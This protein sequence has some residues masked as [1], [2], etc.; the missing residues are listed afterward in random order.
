MLEAVSF[1]SRLPIVENVPVYRPE[2]AV[3]RIKQAFLPAVAASGHRR[4]MSGKE[5]RGRGQAWP[6][7]GEILAAVSTLHKQLLIYPPGPLFFDEIVEFV[8]VQS[9]LV[10]EFVL[11]LQ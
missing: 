1:R 9:Q 10:Q 2:A 7:V 5:S 4:R 6:S 3:S 8:L 11:G